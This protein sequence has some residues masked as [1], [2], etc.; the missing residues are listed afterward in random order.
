MIL[1]MSDNLVTTV[2]NFKLLNNNFLSFLE[3][4]PVVNFKITTFGFVI[5]SWRQS[6]LSKHNEQKN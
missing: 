5:A 4:S 6:V 2:A 1:N 3:K